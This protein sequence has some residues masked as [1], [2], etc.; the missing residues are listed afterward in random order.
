M[1]HEIRNLLLAFFGTALL[2]AGIY[3]SALGVRDFLKPGREIP[4][5]VETADEIYD[6]TVDND[7]VITGNLCIED[8]DDRRCLPPNVFSWRP[9]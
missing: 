4:A 3:M 8:G 6:R 2:A 7:I 5:R 9:K 1:K